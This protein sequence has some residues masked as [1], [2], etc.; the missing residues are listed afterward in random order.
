[1]QLV[2]YFQLGSNGRREP[3]LYTFLDRAAEALVRGNR[4]AAHVVE[5]D[6]PGGVVVR[7]FT[8]QDCPEIVRFSIPGSSVASNA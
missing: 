2:R 1:V 6:M 4:P 8:L 5:L 7:E 3:E